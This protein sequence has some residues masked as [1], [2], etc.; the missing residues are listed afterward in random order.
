MIT[1]TTE[2]FD[3]EYQQRQDDAALDAAADG[4]S[5]GWEG[6][7]PQFPTDSAY[8]SGFLRGKLAKTELILNQCQTTLQSLK[9]RACDQQTKLDYLGRSLEIVA[10]RVLPDEGDEF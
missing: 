1:Q 3:S 10:N 4:A 9:A 8:M 5:D 6:L 2:Y 7:E